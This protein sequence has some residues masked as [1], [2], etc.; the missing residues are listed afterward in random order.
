MVAGSEPPGLVP[1]LLLARYL[2]L[3]DFLS[4]PGWF[5]AEV[6]LPLRQREG[7]ADILPIPQAL[8]QTKTIG[9]T[10]KSQSLNWGMDEQ[11]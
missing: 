10:T 11:Q 5:H 3:R 6:P 8:G 4:H 1:G 9:T 2:Q 7:I